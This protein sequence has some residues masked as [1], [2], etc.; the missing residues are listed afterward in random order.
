MFE[1]PGPQP[2]PIVA[3]VL[4]VSA[5][6]EGRILLQ[7]RDG[8]APTSPNTWATPGGHIEP[9]ESAE[10]AAYRELQEEIGLAPDEPL[11][12][13]M[14]FLICRKEDGSIHNASIGDAIPP[15]AK[16]IRDVSIFYG[17]TTVRLEDVVLREG[18]GLAFFSPQ[19]ALQLE[20]ATSTTYVLPL[21]VNSPE[22]RNLLKK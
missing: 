17:T 3:G 1:S 5:D 2:W 16:V 18:D 15:D 21:F 9:G 4:L 20:L 14:H 13:F 11:T 19:E 6:G 10:E 12:L 22:Y 7:H 8:N